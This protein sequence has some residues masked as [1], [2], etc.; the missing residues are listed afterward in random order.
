MSSDLFCAVRGQ[1]PHSLRHLG[2][3]QGRLRTRGSR[4]S[5]EETRSELAAAPLAGGMKDRT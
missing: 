1:P 4:L 5:A 3:G 2:L